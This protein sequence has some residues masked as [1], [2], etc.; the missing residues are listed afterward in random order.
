MPSMGLQLTQKVP[1][2][3][4]L[5]PREIKVFMEICKTTACPLGETICEYG[6]ASRRFFILL[7]GALKII[8]RDG[9]ALADVRPVATVGEMG[10]VNHK[11]RSATVVTSEPS[12]LLRV[13]HHD[14]ESLLDRHVDLRIKVYRNLVRVVSDRLN[15][16]ND[17]LTRYKKLY[18]SGRVPEREKAPEPQLDEGTG[19]ETSVDVD[20]ED[21]AVPVPS[22]EQHAALIAL[23]YE[24][25][26]E[27]PPDDLDQDLDQFTALQNDGYT[28]ADVE[29]AIKWTARH[30][31]SAK[32]FSMVRLSIEEAF[33]ER[34]NL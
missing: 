13:E 3:F 9:T 20:S 5:K 27:T 14:F 24:L 16:A 8:G 22:A 21:A 4:G 2:F 33:E 30:I 19:D 23:F 10:F 28:C 1:L 7:E 29:F 12:R 11:P 18:E 25:I 17:M 32:R 34:W 6:T 26:S 15:D 31:P